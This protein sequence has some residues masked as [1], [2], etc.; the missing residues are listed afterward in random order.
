MVRKLHLI[1]VKSVVPMVAVS[2]AAVPVESE[3]S[4][5]VIAPDPPVEAIAVPVIV[6]V[7]L[8]TFVVEPLDWTAVTVM[9]SFAAVVADVK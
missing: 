3:L 2:P 9:K 7:F 4:V 6:P 5:R 8:K 1:L